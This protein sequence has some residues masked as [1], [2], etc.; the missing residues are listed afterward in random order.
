MH[1]VDFLFWFVI[2]IILLYILIFNVYIFLFWFI[3]VI[4]SLYIIIKIMFNECFLPWRENHRE[5]LK[6]QSLQN[7]QNKVMYEIKDSTS[8]NF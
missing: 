2:V 6:N 5:A 8:I 7:E 4:I 1:P 3:L